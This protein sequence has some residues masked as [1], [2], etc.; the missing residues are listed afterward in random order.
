MAEKVLVDKIAIKSRVRL[1]NC[2]RIQEEGLRLEEAKVIVAGGGGVGAEGFETA[3][4][5]GQGAQRRRWGHP[6]PGG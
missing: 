4:R 5:A 2:E 6:C 3:G 1:A